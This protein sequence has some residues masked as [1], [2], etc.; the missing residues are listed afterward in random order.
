[1]PNATNVTSPINIHGIGRSGTTL[2]QNIMAET[3]FI[4]TCNEMAPFVFGAFRGAQLGRPS[5]DKEIPGR[6]GDTVLAVR[7]VHG[8]MCAACPS[9]K[10]GWSQKL[11]GIPNQLVWSMI[12]QAD[13]DFASEPYP[14][15]YQW[16]WDAVAAM[17]PLS[18]D[19]LVLRDYRDILISGT[20]FFGHSPV[21]LTADLAVYFNLLAHPA[22][23]IGHVIR[24]EQLVADP[25][26]TVCELFAY[27]GLQYRPE[28]L[29]AMR[30]YAASSGTRSLEQARVVA[31]SWPDLY[32]SV[33]DDPVRGVMAPALE[34]LEARLGMELTPPASAARF[35]EGG[36]PIQYER[37][38]AVGAI[39]VGPFAYEIIELWKTSSSRDYKYFD[40]VE[41]QT[42]VFWKPGSVF[43]EQ[44][45]LM[46]RETIVEVACGKGRHTALAVPLCGTIWA[47]DTS[48]DALKELTERFRDVPAV[49]PL[50]VTGESSLP[51]VG[52]N[53]VTAVFSYD[54]MV[55]FEM[56]TVAAYLAEVS[57]ILR[58]GGKA[59]FH[60]SNYADNPEGKFTDNPGWRNYMTP[61]IMR[62]LASRNGLR[63]VSQTVLDWT[64]PQL[65]MLT[66]LQKD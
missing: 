47:T 36:E 5:E 11:G 43:R 58:K 10:P 13:R 52:S 42:A 12:T 38:R 44:F 65:D 59:L 30:E 16:Y 25:S 29:D 3:G 61:E 19:V 46:D 2:I 33:I 66:S 6:Y 56:Q 60:H 20:K 14:F 55:H 27:L 51:E 40:K 24:F 63:V 21:D 34:R 28:L 50:L 22:A 45:E 1:M 41:E 15:P 64:V 54:S 7:A 32:A 8:A 18:K 49:R 17:F 35:R 31:F 37:R 9:S 53:S 23:R 57:R 48:V 62:H 26:R 39:A 4:Q